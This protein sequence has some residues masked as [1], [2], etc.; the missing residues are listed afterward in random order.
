MKTYLKLAWRNL[1]RNKRRTLITVSS[2]LFGV[3]FVVMM[4]SLQQGSFENMIDN[5]VRFYSGYI[6][7]Q[8]DGFF[9]NRSLNNSLKFTNEIEDIIN[10]TEGIT[11]YTQRIES[12]ALASTG[13]KSF[14]AAIFGILP[15]EE[16][17]ISGLSKKVSQG[18]YIASGSKGIMIGKGLADNLGIGLNDTLILLGQGYHG[19]TAAGKYHVAALLNF[20]INDM[21]N[22]LAYLD[23]EAC[24][25]LYDLPGRSTSIVIMVKKPNDVNSIISNLQTKVPEGLM[26]YSWEEI[27]AELM[28]L[29][30]GKKASSKI[31]KA[32]LFMVIG[33]GIWGTIIM[34]MA[35][36]KRELGIMVAVGVRKIRLIWIVAIESFLI[37]ILGIVFGFLLSFPL[38][39]YLYS[40]PIHVTGKVAETYAQMG[41][42]PVIKFA[43]HPDIFSSPA[44]T[45]FALFAIITL[46]PVWFI[47]KLKTAEALRS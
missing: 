27:Q 25:E 8:E 2:I 33:F 40:N 30:S 14:G 23:M 28:S 7:I 20:P 9:E 34:L 44:I 18:E 12:F 41:F 13:D 5:M 15:P 26:V 39:Y 19:V 36:R 21:N 17:Q 10:N 22:K 11:Q 42:E 43:L 35:E 31:I 38:V 16:D 24:R 4:T 1:W 46:Y 32:I 37:G 29:I 6:Q 3:F 45:V 47:K